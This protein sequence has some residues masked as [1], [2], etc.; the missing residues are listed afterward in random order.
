MNPRDNYDDLSAGKSESAFN[1]CD[2]E[3]SALP[4]FAFD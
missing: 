4:A 3:P 1:Q 2:R